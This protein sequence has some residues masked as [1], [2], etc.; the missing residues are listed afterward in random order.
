[1][2]PRQAMLIE[3]Y[4]GY[5]AMYKTQITVYGPSEPGPFVVICDS[6][7]MKAINSCSSSALG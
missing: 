5:N 6:G 4:D 7:P 1:M 2:S 3:G